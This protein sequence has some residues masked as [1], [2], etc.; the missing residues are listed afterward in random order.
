MV[1]KEDLT[2]LLILHLPAFRQRLIYVRKH[3]QEPD[4]LLVMLVLLV[5]H[6]RVGTNLLENQIEVIVL[7]EEATRLA[8]QLD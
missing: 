7:L 1:N 5:V 6:G 2:T 8:V 3:V 4:K